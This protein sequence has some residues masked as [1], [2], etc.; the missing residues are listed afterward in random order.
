MPLTPDRFAAAQRWFQD[1]IAANHKVPELLTDFPEATADDGY[2]LQ[3][4]QIGQR[5][6]GGEHI[7]GYKV[8]LSSKPM[9]AFFGVNEPCAGVLTSN[10]LITT[11]QVSVGNWVQANVEPEIAFLLG[12]PL[13]G[14]HVTVL[15]V[16]TAT[17]GVMAALEIGHLRTGVEKR[18]MATF[19]GLNTL[20]AGVV[21]GDRVVEPRG[22][23]LRLEGMYLEID[24]EPAGSGCGVEALG[25][26][27]AV[28]AWIANLFA[29]F[30]RRLEA[31]TFIITGSLVQGPLMKPGKAVR[32]RYTNL[33]E[34]GVRFTE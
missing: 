6:A 8:A 27:R 9:Q 12:K 17:E 30:E 25:D 20:N 33:G 3:L 22:L 32:A 2:R 29:R 21:L 26:P 23:D 31:G 1:H 15:D 14:P 19:V 24:G 7:V 11:G 13:E 28:V 16:M 34:V 18:S 5:L 10:G 4:A